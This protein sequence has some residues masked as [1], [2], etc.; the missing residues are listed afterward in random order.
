[1]GHLESHTQSIFVGFSARVYEEDAVEM[2]TGKFRE[3]GS[4][5]HPHFH[6]YCIT[7]KIAQCGL[8]SDRTRPTRMLVT[9][10]RNGMSA[11][12]VENPATVTR[13]QPDTLG[14]DDLDGVLR[15]DRRE[16]IGGAHGMCP[17]EIRRER[18]KSSLAQRQ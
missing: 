12:Q 1:V 17:C 11:I 7:L 13:V 2:P 14:I 5:A 8:T 4:S 6:G 9:E 18:F 3:F 16:M 15:K 10:G